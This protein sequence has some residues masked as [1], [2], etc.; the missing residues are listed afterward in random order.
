MNCPNLTNITTTTSKQEVMNT[1][2]TNY[3]RLRLSHKF[4]AKSGLGTVPH[5]YVIPKNKDILDKNRVI[6]SYYRFPMR[7]LLKLASK[8]L[9]FC[10]RNLKKNYRHFTLHR[11]SDTKP[12]LKKLTRKWRKQFGKHANVDV[13]ATDL[14]QMYT[15]LHHDEIRKATLWLFERIR[16]GKP[17]GANPTAIAVAPATYVNER[18]S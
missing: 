6:T 16:N 8:A 4:P 11:L 7:K 5:S 3:G 14:K 18:S 9:T 1:I 17:T 2:R 13:I 15:F 10:L 12:L